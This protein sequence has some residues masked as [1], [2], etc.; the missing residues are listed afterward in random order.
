MLLL[1]ARKFCLNSAVDSNVLKK[2]PASAASHNQ[3]ASAE[4]SRRPLKQ[5]PIGNTNN[6][7]WS[8]VT[9]RKNNS[10]KNTTKTA[11]CPSVSISEAGTRGDNGGNV[12]KNDDFATA[13]WNAEKSVVI[14]N[15]NL[16]QAP[17]LNPATISAKVT[18]ALIQ[19]AATN[20]NNNDNSAAGEMVNDLISQVK[21]MDFFGKGTKPCKDPKNA[22]INNSYYTIPIK[23][24]F[25]NKQVSKHV[26][27]I[28]RQKYKVSTS[29][30][31][32]RT[33]KK[34]MPLA[35]E[36]ISKQNPGK[37]VL[38]SLDAPKKC[39]KPF[40]RS[41]PTGGDRSVDS[42]WTSAG[43][44]IQLPLDAL[45]PKLKEISSEFSLPASPTPVNCDLSAE[46]QPPPG[47]S[48]SGT[49][50]RRL[51]LSPQL[52]KELAEKEGRRRRRRKGTRR[53][54]C[55]MTPWTA[56]SWRLKM[57]QKVKKK[58]ARAQCPRTKMILGGLLAVLFASL[59]IST[60]NT[61]FTQDSVLRDMDP[62]SF[63]AVTIS[64]VNCKYV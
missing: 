16:G 1:D 48:Q 38:I 9:N 64:S 54:A 55:L 22:S 10:K 52:A 4:A 57:F 14:Y 45:N 33:L 27:E 17:L 11:D 12:Q 2:T 60:L 26:N 3:Y 31:Y 25:S 23:L 32:H 61:F 40:T 41:P 59:S 13:I 7:Q 58:A 53:T 51:K 49:Q 56:A 5:A 21:G 20:I 43:N 36:K 47:F 28:L 39:L 50:A 63:P 8:Q 30:P 6:N 46:S 44:P 42:S 34:A 18:T 24:T 19:A 35:H 29:I 37:Q 62:D 15:L